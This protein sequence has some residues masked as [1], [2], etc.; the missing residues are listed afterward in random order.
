MTSVTVANISFPFVEEDRHVKFLPLDALSL[1]GALEAAGHTVDF[2][3]HQQTEI[4]YADP[5][6]PDHAPSFFADAAEAVIINAPHDAL[7]VAILWAERLKSIDPRRTI[8][9]SG[10]GPQHVAAPILQEFSFIDAVIQGPPELVGPQLIKGLEGDWG[11]VPGIA[12]RYRN[13]IYSNPPPAPLSTLDDLPLPAYEKVDISSYW[14]IMIFSACGCPFG[15]SFCVRRGRLVE[16]GIDAVMREISTL[17][18]LHGQKRVFFYD[19]TFTLKKERVLN[20]CQRLQ[21]DGL[22]D[23]EWSCTGRLNLTDE[24]LMG[25][26]AEAGCKMIYFGVESG[27]DQV[28]KLINKNIS[29]AMAEQAIKEAQRFFFVNTFFIWGFPFESTDD[30]QKTVDMILR[31]TEQGVAPIIY[32]LSPLPS[33]LLYLQYSDQL[34]FSR[35]VWE[36][37]W[38]VHLSDPVSR[39]CLAR[40]IE[41]HPRVFPGFHTCDPLIL[42]KLKIVQQLGLETHFPDV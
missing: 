1:V 31:L 22:N 9:L 19:Q 2:R 37:N 32:V 21:A 12:F 16:K 41:A 29:R 28:L 18:H 13:D 42:D 33:S 20:L 25:K 3:D 15:C 34:R 23:I 10:Y 39:N 7:P 6:D 14:E 5:Q 30:F 40:L 4:A 36:A 11:K 35:E 17:R 24:E 8:M 27:S 38:P 26:M